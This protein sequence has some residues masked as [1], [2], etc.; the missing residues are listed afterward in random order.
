[1]KKSIIKYLKIA[2]LIVVGIILGWLLFGSSD[3]IETDHSGRDH[4]QL[5]NESG[6]AVWTCSMHPQIR[7]NEPGDCPICGMDLIP[8]N[9][10]TQ[11][12]DPAVM[13]MSESAVN[14]AN[15]QT[16]IIEYSNPEKEIYLNGKIEIDE[17]NIHN[18]I[19]HFS[20]R[21]EKLYVN[22][23]G[24]KVGKGQK[25]ARIYS[26]ELVTAQEELFEAIKLKSSMPRLYYSAKEKLKLWKLSEKQIQQIEDNGK[27]QEELDILADASGYVLNRYISS[28]SQV[29]RGDIL[30][31]IADL[32]NVWVIFDVYE[33][34]IRWIR[35]NDIIDFTVS[36]LPGKEFSAKVRYIDPL[37]NKND[38]TIKVRAELRN[39][40][41]ILK[42]EMFV[43]G[44]IKSKLPIKEKKI[45]IPKSSVMW[46][47]K[48]SVVYIK[49][50][51]TDIPSFEMREIV[52][53]DNLG[54]YYIVE[55]GLDEEEEIVV[56]GTFKIDASAQLAG[57]YSS[58]N[59]PKTKDISS[60]KIPNHVK[61]TPK[62]FK[63]QLKKLILSYLELSDA[64]VAS[65]SKKAKGKM[66]DF[67]KRLKEI[68]MSLLTHNGHEYWMKQMKIL[69]RESAQISGTDNID[70]QR[71]AFIELSEALIRSAK[72]FGTDELFYVL[73][74]PM[75]ND[76]QGANWLSIKNEVLNP[77][78]GDMMLNCGDVVEKIGKK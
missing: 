28:G 20:G 63:S 32:S 64:L 72:S 75:A 31:K 33:N 11:S 47:G 62:E 42:P 74:C 40:N 43:K 56:Y 21:I 10:S 66:K 54:E 59:R 24:Q 70:I 44:L 49:L 7:K 53:G 4:Q 68:D 9:V 26:P 1:M 57:K 5:E 35:N 17:R 45:I 22:F 16:E 29:K 61:N 77:Y 8:V 65:D 15:I 30:F 71:K 69:K 78:F 51:N 58:M 6:E 73:R 52:L 50:Q 3:K 36:S 25:I 37:L 48:R 2:G 39:P 18:Q 60:S 19:S 55:D 12:D 13:E 67:G 34:D 76:D 23:T 27:I 41:N 14:L 46:T 38:R